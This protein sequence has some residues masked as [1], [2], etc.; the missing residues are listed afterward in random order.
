MRT[1]QLNVAR[2]ALFAAA[3]ALLA[4]PGA[5]AHNGSHPQCYSGPPPRNTEG[6]PEQDGFWEDIVDLGVQAIHAIHLPVSGKILI[7]GYNHGQRTSAPGKIYDPA[8]GTTE[9]ISIGTSAFCAGHSH[10]PDGRVFISGGLNSGGLGTIFNPFTETF[11]SSPIQL[12]GNRFYPT[13]ESLSDGRVFIAGGTGKN[14]QVPEIFD[15]VTQ[16]T[17]PVGCID[18]GNG[19]FKCDQTRNKVH[20]FPRIALGDND[21]MLLLPASRPLL[22]YTFDFWNSVW[23]SH[24]NPDDSRGRWRPAPA[25]YYAENRVLRA[26]SDTYG[27]NNSAVAETSVVEFD[28]IFN[29]TERE[30]APLAYARNRTTLTLLAD[31]T[32]LATGGKRESPCSNGDP[33]VY[34]PELWNPATE[35][36]TT[37]GPM[38]CT[39]VYHSTAILLRDGSILSAGG[40]VKQTTSQI[41]RPPYLFY[42]PRPTVSGAPPQTTYGTTFEVFTPDAAS[43]QAVN[44]LRPGAV[45]HA[46]D[47]S[48]RFVPLTFTALVDRLVVDSPDEAYEAPPGFYLLFLIS[49]QGVPSV[50]EY[51]QIVP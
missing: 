41:F 18:L 44:L 28:D 47:Q 8:T 34:H 20:Y 19:K 11:I 26:G 24:E 14:S 45:T 31:G 17:S 9:D 38:Q 1:H 16:T 27:S 3:I 21:N 4:A 29:P 40:E 13:H 36:W 5:R 22:A 39:R 12:Y 7:W 23:V 30:T 46:Y 50:A 2:V 51:V 25:V 49:N 48:Q 6:T 42:G 10:L 43:I 37:L 32:V 33:F 15:P 35:Q